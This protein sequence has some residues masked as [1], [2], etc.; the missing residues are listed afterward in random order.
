MNYTQPGN[1]A[2]RLFPKEKYNKRRPPSNCKAVPTLQMYIVCQRS[3]KGKS[4][5]LSFQGFL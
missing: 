2:S 1:D 3:T 4:Y 5:F